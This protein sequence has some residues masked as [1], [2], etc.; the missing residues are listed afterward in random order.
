MKTRKGI[1]TQVERA[2]AWFDEKRPGWFR[3]VPLT[4]GAF[5]I[6]KALHIRESDGKKCGCV[7]VHVGMYPFNAPAYV[8]RATMWDGMW[9]NEEVPVLQEEW[10]RV[11][12]ER[13]AAARG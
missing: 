1:A 5:Q 13:R 10:E 8:R 11:I 7:T 4:T 12:R 9:A 6:D 2:A 3:K